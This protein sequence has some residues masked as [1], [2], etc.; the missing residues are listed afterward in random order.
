MATEKINIKSCTLREDKGTY[1]TYL[2]LDLQGNKYGATEEFTEGEHEVEIV[3]NGNYKNIK[4]PKPA[5][6]SPFP[7][8]DYK[9]ERRKVALECAIST[10]EKPNSYNDG[11]ILKIAEAYEIWLN[12]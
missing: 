1:K 5:G 4:K 8:K 9:L 7:Q 12:R 10:I 11:K 6:K 2:V 3:I